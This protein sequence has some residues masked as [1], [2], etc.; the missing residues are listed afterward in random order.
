MYGS[1][2]DVGPFHLTNNNDNF[3][4]GKNDEFTITGG[5]VGELRQLKVWHDNK[6]PG[7]SNF[8]VFRFEWFWFCFMC[9]I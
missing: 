5:D 8:D 4:S 9:L 3:E 1:L 2:K 7:P 6:G